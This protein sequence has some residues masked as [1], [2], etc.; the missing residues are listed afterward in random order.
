MA[1]N[2]RQWSLAAD[3]LA[4]VHGMAW[5]HVTSHMTDTAHGDAACADDVLTAYDVMRSTAASSIVVHVR[6][7]NKNSMFENV[8]QRIGHCSAVA[9]YFRTSLRMATVF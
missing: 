7:C 5:M 8:I 3:R 2:G 1:E 6:S 4:A 9:K